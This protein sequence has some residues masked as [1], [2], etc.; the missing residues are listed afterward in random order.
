MEQDEVIRA[1]H[2]TL[3]IGPKQSLLLEAFQL[4]KARSW[5][6]IVFPAKDNDDE[7][8]KWI[9][10]KGLQ[11]EPNGDCRLHIRTIQALTE[12]FAANRDATASL[13]CKGIKARYR[14][15]EKGFLTITFEQGAIRKP[16]I[17]SSF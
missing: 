9:G 3:R 1:R 15:R 14:W 7:T 5:N 2:A 16:C 10:E 12:K 8:R 4:E 13:R 11:K 17:R 6:D